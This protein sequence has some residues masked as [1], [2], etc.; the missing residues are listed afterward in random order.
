[1]LE[2]KIDGWKTNYFPV[3]RRP[4]FQW[5]SCYDCFMECT[6]F[7]SFFKVRSLLNSRVV[8]KTHWVKPHGS[9]QKLPSSIGVINT[10]LKLVQFPAML[11][12]SGNCR[13]YHKEP[14]HYIPKLHYILVIQ[15]I[16]PSYPS[17]QSKKIPQHKL[18]ADC[19]SEKRSVWHGEIVGL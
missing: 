14:T 8:T 5:L 7:L 1:M 4:T 16:I 19:I 6:I 3:G 10:S 15:E 13:F 2:R 9:K 11:D 12:L 18:T 17:L